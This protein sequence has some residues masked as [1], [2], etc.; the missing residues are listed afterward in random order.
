VLGLPVVGR[1]PG[2]RCWLDPW[3]R[4]VPAARSAHRG[5]RTL[6]PS[7]GVGQRR[8]RAPTPPRRSHRT[9]AQAGSGPAAGAGPAAGPTR[10][11]DAN[12]RHRRTPPRSDRQARS[13]PARSRA[14][15][16]E[17]TPDPGTRWSRLDR[18]TRTATQSSC[19][20]PPAAPLGCH[21]GL[22]RSSAAVLRA[23]V[24]G[25]GNSNRNG[26]SDVCIPITQATRPP[27]VK[28]QSLQFIPAQGQ[29][30]I[31]EWRAGSAWYSSVTS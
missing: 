18:R 27:L 6:V 2:A 19:R 17:R 1:E 9:H 20:L 31:T 24:G 5:Q 15:S 25:G 13:S 22:T 3:G 4:P 21:C 23:T 14:A 29:Q 16:Q 10:P 7:P 26:W 11:V 12:S 30:E 28:F 8:K